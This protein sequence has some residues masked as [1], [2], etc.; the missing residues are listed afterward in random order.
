MSVDSSLWDCKICTFANNSSSV[1]CT[2]CGQGEKPSDYW[3]CESCQFVNSIRCVTCSICQQTQPNFQP[4][5]IQDDEQK[6]SKI[7]FES[8]DIHKNNIN[9]SQYVKLKNDL[10][11]GNDIDL[12]KY[13]KLFKLSTSVGFTQTDILEA[14]LVTDTTD[15]MSIVTDYLLLSP[16]LKQQRYKQIMDLKG[17]FLSIM[18]HLILVLICA[19]WIRVFEDDDFL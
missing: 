16:S 8:Q 19:A 18:I 2:M 7:K 4:S 14:A 5:M 13:C 17:T 3:E 6:S 11:D 15:D 9:E 10:N 1:V 12:S